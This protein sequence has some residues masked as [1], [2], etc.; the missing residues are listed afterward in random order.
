MRGR[1]S[2]IGLTPIQVA[3]LNRNIRRMRRLAF[4]ARLVTLWRRLAYWWGRLR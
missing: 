3:M 2:E 1:E 4:I